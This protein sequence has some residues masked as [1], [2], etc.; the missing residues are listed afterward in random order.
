MRL[1]GSGEVDLGQIELLVKVGVP[2]QFSVTNSNPESLSVAHRKEESTRW[3][4][5]R[6]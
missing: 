6:H 4:Y 5:T 2:M 3:K 1:L